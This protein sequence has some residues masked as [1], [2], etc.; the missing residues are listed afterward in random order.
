M[1]VIKLMRALKGYVG[2]FHGMTDCQFFTGTES[3]AP[4]AGAV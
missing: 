2:H 1:T 3:S 4:A